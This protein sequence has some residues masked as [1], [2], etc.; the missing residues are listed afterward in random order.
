MEDMATLLKHLARAQQ[1]VAQ[2]EILIAEQKQRIADLRRD[3]HDTS[4]SE[5]LLKTMLETQR[6]HEEAV[7]TITSEIA[8][9]KP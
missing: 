6:L 4:V 1:H 9:L 5:S 7:A 3:G 8:E 2:G